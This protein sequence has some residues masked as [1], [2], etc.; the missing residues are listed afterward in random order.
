MFEHYLTAPLG[1]RRAHDLAHSALP[2]A[3]V[4]PSRAHSPGSG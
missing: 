3:P 1:L 2:D 4:Q